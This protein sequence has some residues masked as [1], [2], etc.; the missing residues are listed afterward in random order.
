MLNET[1]GIL[2][3]VAFWAASGARG[4]RTTL[5]RPE[6]PWDPP[7][8]PWDPPGTALGPPG[9]PLEPNRAPG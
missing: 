2:E 4:G 8:L 3:A 6:L 7:E 9:T 5:D 1:A